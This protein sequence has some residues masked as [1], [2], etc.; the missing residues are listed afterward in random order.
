MQKEKI[1]YNL[2]NLD[3][4]IYN[5]ILSDSSINQLRKE[6][7]HREAECLLVLSGKVVLNIAGKKTVLSEGQSAF[8]GRDLIHRIIPADKPSKIL[9]LQVS[10]SK[11]D[12]HI[13]NYQLD[14]TLLNY[15]L[16]N[17]K[18]SHCVFVE[19]NNE[20]S[21]I[22]YKVNDELNA[23]KPYYEAYIKAYVYNMI[24]FL[25]R[26][27]LL[28][29]DI[30]KDDFPALKKLDAISAYISENF[31][32]PLTLDMVSEDVK[33]NKYYI[34]KLFKTI[35]NTTFTGYLN[36]VRCR[37][38]KFLLFSTNETI[39]EIAY[40]SG[41]MSIQNFNKNFKTFYNCTPYKYKKLY[42][43]IELDYN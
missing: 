20:F 2:K 35:L 40:K 31:K 28:S 42:N 15:I 1:V 38:A 4:R 33:Y 8:I 5:L 43:P 18:E 32:K 6:H 17:Q 25:K 26:N 19:K 30:T 14:S 39:A 22:L 29:E 13:R 24:A 27:N 10:L 37:N 21:D 34:C 3:I 16:E 23:S 41:F 36:F 11:F 9:I 12:E 7:F